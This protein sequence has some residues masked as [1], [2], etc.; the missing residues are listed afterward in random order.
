[1]H[2][3][4]DVTPATRWAPTVQAALIVVGGSALAFVILHNG[5]FI[6]RLKPRGKNKGAT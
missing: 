5:W 6:R 1:V 3:K 2:L 4:V